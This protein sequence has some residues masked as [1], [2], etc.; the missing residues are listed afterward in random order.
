MTTNKISNIPKLGFKN[1]A[2][3]SD[4][5]TIPNL[6]FENVIK[7]TWDFNHAERAIGKHYGKD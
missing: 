6:R 2:K 5:S 4:I 7:N 3:T 1:N